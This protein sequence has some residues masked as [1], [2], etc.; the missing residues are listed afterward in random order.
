MAVE[1]VRRRQPDDSPRDR[2][3]RAYALYRES[4]LLRREYNDTHDP[5]RLDLAID[6]ATA[7]LAVLPDGDPWRPVMIGHLAAHLHQ[8]YLVHGDAA[9]LGESVRLGREAARGPHPRPVEVAGNLCGALMALF[10]LT[11]DH[12]ALDEAIEQGRRA[13][14]IASPGEPLKVM[15]LS[16][17]AAALAFAHRFQRK[18]GA[19]DESLAI[20]REAVAA[21]P[22]ED[23][24][25]VNLLHNLGTGLRMRYAETGDIALLEE[26][27][28]RGRE[29]AEIAPDNPMYLGSAAAHHLVRFLRKGD[30]ADVSQALAWCREGLAR[31]SPGHPHRPAL[32]NLTASALSLL[33]KHTGDRAAAREAVE[34]SRSAVAATPAAHHDLPGH[35][36]NLSLNLCFLFGRTRETALLREAVDVTRKALD[37]LPPGHPERAGCHSALTEMLLALF[38]H[39]QEEGLLREALDAAR[40]ALADAVPGSPPYVPALN[41]L[42]IVLRAGHEVLRDPGA[43]PE[44]VERAREAVRLAGDDPRRGAYLDTLSAALGVHDEMAAWSPAERRENIEVA[45]RA[46]A[47]AE[48]TDEERGPKLGALAWAMLAMT[49]LP[50]GESMIAEAVTY[51]REAV[52]CLPRHAATA[53]TL[54]AVLLREHELEHGDHLAEAADVLAGGLAATASEPRNRLECA[55]TL[56]RVHT[57]AGRP[58]AAL[59]AMERAVALL[60]SVAPRSLVRGARERGLERHF[61]I[62]SEAAAAALTA[63]RPGHAVELLEQTRGVLLAEVIGSRD[64]NLEALRPDLAEELVMLRD[65]SAEPALSDQTHDQVLTAAENRRELAGRW[66]DLLARIRRV[67]ELEGFLRPPALADLSVGLDEGPIVTV[68]CSADRADALILDGTGVRPVRLPRLDGAQAHAWSRYL[69]AGDV[70]QDHLLDL[71]AWLWDT[72]AEP[73]LDALDLAPGS[74]VWWNPVGPLAS[75]PLHAAGRHLDGT[76]ASVLDRVVSSYTPTIRSLAHARSRRDHEPATGRALIVAVPD[77]AGQPALPGTR[78]ETTFIAEL[79]PDARVF[80][81]AGAVKEGL[82]A[83]LPDCGVVH[84]A[85]HARID[86]ASPM[87]SG[88]VLAGRDDAP[89]T[90]ASIARLDLGGAQLAYLSACDTGVTRPGLADEAVHLTAGFQLAGYPQ[91]IGTLWEVSDRISARIAA[92]VYAGSVRQGRLAPERVP[93]A[94]H[95]AIVAARD[96][97]PRAPSLWAA[98]VHHGA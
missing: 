31:T 16:N 87:S 43:L 69:R 13:V 21:L 7:A 61:G 52:R 84:F 65:R 41:N 70:P 8:R 57:R 2:V 71:L 12:A 44:A 32:L 48:A 24:R 46:L 23:P 63:D 59:E 77:A 81:G 36:R 4:L 91:V 50:D 51:A 5:Q 27:C 80:T 76:G 75:L 64:G 17:L 96:D 66:E 18:P 90:L 15:C 1:P 85:C 26:A 11:Q 89:L 20:E 39:T 56:A 22:R 47:E 74:R 33:S 10:E 73:V 42:S 78:R 72:V 58:D 45:R 88:I 82:L 67:P 55:R 86:H 19:L 95:R 29:A 53:L 94:L 83:A 98:H 14:K 60:P 49:S 79:L 54:G 28:A 68:T 9:A 93:H 6:R 3:A 25:R 97:F 35:L 37:A 38:D 30:L 40:Q 34:F 62:A 92:E